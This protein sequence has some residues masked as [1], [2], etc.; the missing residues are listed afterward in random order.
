MQS[1]AL[2]EGRVPAPHEFRA[3]TRLDIE[4]D[5]SIA[6][7]TNFFL[8]LTENISEGGLF[9]AT[10]VLRPV[11]TKLELKLTLPDGG[12]PFSVVGEVRWL[13]EYSESSNVSPGMGLR[14]QTFDDDKL[15]RIR[16]FVAKKSP[17]FYED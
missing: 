4:L 12:P 1:A 11:G 5:V 10:H 3:H 17:L 6:S 7:E 15:E 9:V 16:A 8:G 14:F 13:R 2:E